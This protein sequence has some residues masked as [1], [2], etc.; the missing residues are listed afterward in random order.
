MHIMPPTPQRNQGLYAGD[1]PPPGIGHRRPGVLL[2]ER[3]WKPVCFSRIKTVSAS[4]PKP[5]I[6]CFYPKRRRA[7]LKS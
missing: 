3:R 5:R 7:A 1:W 2:I 4:K 6:P